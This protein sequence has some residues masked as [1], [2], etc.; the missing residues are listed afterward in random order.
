MYEK[1]NNLRAIS[2]S[3]FWCIFVIFGA[4]F[5][6]G[7]NRPSS[8]NAGTIASKFQFPGVFP[9]RVKQSAKR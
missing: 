2:F 3:N 4:Q 5:S 1:N 7:S 6:G 8:Q 9:I